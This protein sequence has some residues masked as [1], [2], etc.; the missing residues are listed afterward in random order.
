MSVDVIGINEGPF[1]TRLK[2]LSDKIYYPLMEIKK[3]L[4]ANTGEPCAH[5]DVPDHHHEGELCRIIFVELGTIEESTM[6]INYVEKSQ[7]GGGE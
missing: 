3:L 2:E 7:T 1:A 4:T 5:Y 6:T